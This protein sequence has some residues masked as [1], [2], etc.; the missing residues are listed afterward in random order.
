MALENGSG[1]HH[2][3]KAAAKTDTTNNVSF[4]PGLLSV[5]CIVQG[6]IDKL[7]RKFKMKDTDF[8]VP[9]D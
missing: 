8:F 1:A 3:C 7:E 4:A 5:P 9:G 6:T 2:C